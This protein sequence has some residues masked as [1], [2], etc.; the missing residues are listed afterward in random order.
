MNTILNKETIKRETEYLNNKEQ[1]NQYLLK[2]NWSY[3]LRVMIEKLDQVDDLN[4]SQSLEMF[5]LISSLEDA[6]QSYYRLY[7]EKTNVQKN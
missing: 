5:K 4:Q 2:F 3:I 7:S 6:L 1:I